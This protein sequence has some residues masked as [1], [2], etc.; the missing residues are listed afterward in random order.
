MERL[1][2]KN[3]V[4]IGSEGKQLP[5]VDIFVEDGLIK[6]IA[7][8]ITPPSNCEIMDAE[9]A[10]ASAG[11][12]DAHTHIIWGED[13]PQLDD[14][15][16]YPHDGLT[17]IVDAGSSGPAGYEEV[18]E[19]MKNSDIQIKAYLNVARNGISMSGGEL[20]SMDYL[21][22]D[23]FCKTHE[24]YPDEIIGVK[25][26]I[27]PRV[28]VNIMAS[29]EATREIADRLNLPMIVHPSRCPENLET[30]LP[31]FKEG[32]VFAHTYSALEPCILD[33]DGKVKECVWDARKR[34][35]W[36]DLSHGSANFSFDVARQAMDQGFVI[37]TISTDLHTMNL[38]GPVRSMTDVMNKMLCLGMSL[39]DIICKVT[40][41]P[42]EMLGIQDKDFDVKN[43]RPAD[44]TI[45]REV[46]G[47]YTF[48]DS[49]GN[50]AESCKRIEVAATVCGR[51]LYFPRH[52][53]FYHNK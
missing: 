52:C 2:I 39:E 23:M 20:K 32:D 36:F 1:L 17:C 46:S 51:S 10:Y 37:D 48:Q 42:L 44:I 45:F 19:K 9:G 26:R 8:E 18:H 49:Y 53:V 22:K 40:K 5:A 43:G 33:K 11:W 30:I 27:D 16:I 34:G 7:G 38:K 28:N 15:L 35:V 4:L 25:I 41:T 3:V 14:K 6:D 12:T 31:L 47:E 50:T 24:K 21:D 29:L 13:S